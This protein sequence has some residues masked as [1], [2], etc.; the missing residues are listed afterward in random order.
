MKY[1]KLRGIESRGMLLCAEGAN[2]ALHLMQPSGDG[3]EAVEIG[4]KV[5]PQGMASVIT[6]SMGKKDFQTVSKKLLAGAQ[7]EACFMGKVL[8]VNG[9]SV[10]ITA[11]STVA[12][13]AQ[14]R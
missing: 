9:S 14:I 7:S 1:A 8:M 12:E 2:N 11:D 13:G 6:P 4:S 10:A 5:V 3:S